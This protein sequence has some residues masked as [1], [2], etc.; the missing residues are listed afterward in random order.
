MDGARTRDQCRKRWNAL[1]KTNFSD[2]TDSE[3]LLL[4]EA[5]HSS[6]QNKKVIWR[7]VSDKMNNRTPGQCWARWNH[8]L[9]IR[10]PLFWGGPNYLKDSIVISIRS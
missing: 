4:K 3:D 1:Q 9:L 2:W 5:V 10:D 8:V 7:E 6:I